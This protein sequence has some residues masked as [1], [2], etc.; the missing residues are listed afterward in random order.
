MAW[1][2]PVEPFRSGHNISY[3]D[4]RLLERLGVDTRYVWPGASPSSPTQVVEGMD[5]ML[6]GF[7]QSW[8]RAVPYY[9]PARG[10]LAR[11]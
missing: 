9:Y 2:D 8:I 4:D 10:I 6:D 11:G 1:G 7:G 3:M 5:T